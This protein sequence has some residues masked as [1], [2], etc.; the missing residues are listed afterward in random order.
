[1]RLQLFFVRFKC[2]YHPGRVEHL[3]WQI[4]MTAAA[5]D[6]LFMVRSHLFEVGS[7]RLS[8]LLEFEEVLLD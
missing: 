3:G 5:I 2:G 6:C 7:W 1:M 4:F 8:L